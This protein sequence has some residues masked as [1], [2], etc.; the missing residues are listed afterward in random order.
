M[1]RSLTAMGLLFLAMAAGTGCVAE[2]K[3]RD[4][5][6]AWRNSQEQLAERDAR[7][8][9]LESQ[10]ALLRQGPERDKAT[11]LALTQENE[12]LRRRLDELQRQYQELAGRSADIIVLDPQTDR[13][14]RDFAAQHP[15]LVEYDPVRGML[16]LRSDVT[17][18]LGSADLTSNARSTLGQ[19][20]GI[21]NS[22][23]TQQYEIRIIG[24]TDSVRIARPDTRAKHP[25]NWHLS[26]HR[27]ISVRDALDT[28]GVSPVRMM[29]GGYSMYRP[30]APNTRG[31]AEP[32]RRVEIYLVGMTP[33]NEQF[34]G[35]AA[36]AVPAPRTA[37]PPAAPRPA[38]G[39][40]PAPRGAGADDR[41]PLK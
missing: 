32:N 20:A 11:I 1:S 36:G 40:A 30:V 25:T 14:L 23:A 12:E 2:N 41:I 29:I 21:L 6:Q 38:S 8:A 26:A 17:F 35:E 37:A 31:G 4:L 7:L 18:A 39:E 34:L 5:E 13:A 24:H 3:Y 28:S 19:L 33:V 10:L 16:K 9:E 22:P 27:A 15:D